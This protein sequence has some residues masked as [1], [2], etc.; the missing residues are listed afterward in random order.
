MAWS[1]TGW[2][3]EL[4]SESAESKT[5]I[6]SMCQLLPRNAP[7]PGT[8]RAER[9]SPRRCGPPP[10]TVEARPRWLLAAS[11]SA[12]PYLVH[13]MRAAAQRAFGSQVDVDGLVGQ[14][15]DVLVR[16]DLGSAPTVYRPPARETGRSRWRA[17][18]TGA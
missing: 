10:A 7:S 17:S 16:G 13:N 4:A 6:G 3:A 2:A 11:V 18:A 14:D 9:S 1:A 15:G 12:W 8:K 5:V